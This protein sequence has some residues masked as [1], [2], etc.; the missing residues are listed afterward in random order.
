MYF[1]MIKKNCD[2]YQD[3]KNQLDMYFTL[4]KLAKKFNLHNDIMRLIISAIGV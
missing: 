4:K 3:Y 1:Y 2:T